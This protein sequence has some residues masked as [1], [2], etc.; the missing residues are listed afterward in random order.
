MPHNILLAY[1]ANGVL[2]HGKPEL[3][4]AKITDKPR[5]KGPAPSVGSLSAAPSSGKPSPVQ[6]PILPPSAVPASPPTPP[7]KNMPV[8][9][10]T[11]LEVEMTRSASSADFLDPVKA[12]PKRK[13]AEPMPP[14]KAAKTG[15]TATPEDLL[16]VAWA[17]SC[18]AP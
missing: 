12:P 10:K 8:E 14:P 16:R 15:P 7:Y 3:Y 1:D 2:I 6:T 18:R 11:R 4:K 5:P 9:L 13:A 17:R